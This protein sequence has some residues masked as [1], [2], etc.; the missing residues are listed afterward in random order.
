MTSIVS[1]PFRPIPEEWTKNS[2]DYVN[3]HGNILVNDKPVG[4]NQIKF[5]R[6]CLNRC[7]IFYRKDVCGEIK[8][9]RPENMSCS[10]E[11]S[12]YAAENFFSQFI[13][14]DEDSK[15]KNFQRLI[16]I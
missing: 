7:D 16:K 2:S 4:L 5:S 13:G 3:P 1:S 11:L 9:S 8:W 15:T 10:K 6:G 12:F 14:N